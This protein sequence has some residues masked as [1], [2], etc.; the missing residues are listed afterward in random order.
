MCS[1]RS[2]TQCATRCWTPGSF[3][4][5][6]RSDRARSSAGHSQSVLQSSNTRRQVRRRDAKVPGLSNG[7]N[8]RLAFSITSCARAAPDRN[9][10]LASSSE[11]VR[12]PNPPP[13]L[14]G[15]CSC[16]SWGDGCGR[17]PPGPSPPGS[18][19]SSA[20][21]DRTAVSTPRVEVATWR[22]STVRRRC[23]MRTFNDI[24]RSRNLV[25]ADKGRLRHLSTSAT[26]VC[27]RCPS[28]CAL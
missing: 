19:S 22:H 21:A 15:S 6:V 1:L 11:V 20:A 14:K 13:L 5:I 25:C 10:A 26:T 18:R 28:T 16:S 9:A 2:A 27:A 23:F 4:F 8:G 12:R 3:T 17:K 7:R 24:C